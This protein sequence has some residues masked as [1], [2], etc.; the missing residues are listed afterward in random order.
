[1]CSTGAVRNPKPAASEKLVGS[2][3]SSRGAS[4]PSTAAGCSIHSGSTRRTDQLPPAE[5]S[6]ARLGACSTAIASIAASA[7]A[8]AAAYGPA[9][10]DA[11]AAADCIE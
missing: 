4:A 6:R 1:M 9:P 5:V 3:N 11:D 8:D 10:A 2:V 7:A